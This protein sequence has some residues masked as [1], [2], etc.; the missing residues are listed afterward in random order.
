ME[1]LLMK[2]LF[3]LYT[4]ILTFLLVT[5]RPH[6]FVQPIEGWTALLE[7][8]AHLIAFTLL[9]FLAA[10]ARTRKPLWLIVVALIAYAAATEIIQGFTAT[11]TPEWKDLIQDVIGVALGTSLGWGASSFLRRIRSG[12]DDSSPR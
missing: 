5:S 1:T 2:I 3:L 8:W 9:A 10:L 12:T 11:R 6:D 7:T 4:A